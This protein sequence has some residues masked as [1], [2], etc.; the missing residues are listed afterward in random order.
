MALWQVKINP[1]QAKNR[2]R[3]TVVCCAAQEAQG[4]QTTVM[5]R[6]VCV[7]CPIRVRVSCTRMGQQD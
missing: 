4:A 1:E 3:H 2:S 6:T 7:F 5:F